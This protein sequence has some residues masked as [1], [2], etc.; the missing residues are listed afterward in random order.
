MDHPEWRHGVKPG[1]GSI[2]TRTTFG[3]QVLDPYTV[4][5][6]K[7]AR[8]KAPRWPIEMPHGPATQR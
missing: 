5:I 8:K 4:R 6:P 1:A 2:Q 7:S 3:V